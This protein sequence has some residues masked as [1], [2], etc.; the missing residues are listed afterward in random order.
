MHVVTQV[1]G[2]TRLPKRS[3]VALQSGLPCSL[4]YLGESGIG[5]GLL[6]LPHV[7]LFLFL[8]LLMVSYSYPLSDQV[9]FSVLRYRNALSL[10]SR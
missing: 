10:P 2:T 8:R 6:H 9:T 5:N 1:S 4:D 7:S 3:L